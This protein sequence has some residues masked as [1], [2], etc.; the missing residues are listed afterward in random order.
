MRW[1]IGAIL[2]TESNSTTPIATQVS[3]AKRNLNSFGVINPEN[4]VT[5]ED[6]QKLS[7]AGEIGKLK[8]IQREKMLEDLSWL[9]NEKVRELE[10]QEQEEKWKETMLQE[11]NTA[12][13]EKIIQLEHAN[14]QLAEEKRHS[15]DL[16]TQLQDAL[17]K[18]RHSEEQLVLERDWL[19]EQVE[20]K[21]LEV[22]ETIRQMIATEGK[23]KEPAK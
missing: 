22:I 13:N 2:S 14:A 10:R 17:Q 12:L 8:S 4:H 3:R 11:L 7:F 20:V 23:D 1:T 16:N 5:A 21:S 6:L 15:D 9:L 19:A 18:L